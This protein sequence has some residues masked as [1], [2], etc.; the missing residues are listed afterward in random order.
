MKNKNKNQKIKN[1]NNM[2]LDIFT[3]ITCILHLFVPTLCVKLQY[4]R[5]SL[6]VSTVIVF[7]YYLF[8]YIY[9]LFIILYLLIYY[10]IYYILSSIY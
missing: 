2:I 4:I 6:H 10:Y 7:I 8:I 5:P 1:H 3:L 9:I